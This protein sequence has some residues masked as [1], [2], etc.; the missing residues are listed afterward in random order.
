M[1][2]W[3]CSGGS[4]DTKRPAKIGG[5]CINI[6][7]VKCNGKWLKHMADA[8]DCT[9]ALYHLNTLSPW[10]LMSTSDIA[11]YLFKPSVHYL[12]FFPRE[13]CIFTKSFNSFRLVPN[14]L[15]FKVIKVIVWKEKIEKIK[16][17]VI[18]PNGH[19]LLA[20]KAGVKGHKWEPPTLLT[21]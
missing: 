1:F 19:P 21:H 10:S 3:M 11:S 16:I 12:Q 2:L 17:K 18:W 8:S 4:F 9:L 15:H 20:H 14:D 13:I 5:S 7:R 6:W